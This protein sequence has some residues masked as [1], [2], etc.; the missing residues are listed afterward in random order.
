M[1]TPLFMDV[2]NIF[3]SVMAVCLQYSP[4]VS[5]KPSLVRRP[6]IDRPSLTIC[7]LRST[8]TPYTH[9]HYR[10]PFTI[11]API[12]SQC[13]YTYHIQPGLLSTDGCT[14]DL[15]SAS[16]MICRGIEVI[17]D[18]SRPHSFPGPSILPPLFD[19]CAEYSKNQAF[20]FLSQKSTQ[21]Q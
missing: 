19:T 17:M 2:Q 14:A 4:T 6:T 1:Y 20:S 21:L 11:S 16:D 3:T 15:T 8:C 13:R 9:Q 10:V 12:S 5:S 7:I 18:I